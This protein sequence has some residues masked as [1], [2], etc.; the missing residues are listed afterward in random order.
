MY[1]FIEAEKAEYSVERL[2]EVLEV[3][4]SAFYRWRHTKCSQRRRDDRELKTH[5]QAIFREHKG[6]YGSPRVRHELSTR[7]MHVSRKRVARLM[8]EEGLAARSP[9]RFRRTT[10]SRHGGAIAPNLLERNFIVDERNKVWVGDVTYL[11]TRDR[12]LYLAVLIDLYSRRVVGWAM[13]DIID[14]Q[15]VRDALRMA[16]RQR[17]PKPGLIHHTDRD[18]RYASEDYREVLTELGATPSMSRKG[19]CWDNAVAE[20]FFATLEH[21][22]FADLPLQSPE[23]TRALV[24]DYIE[25]YYNEKRLHSYLDYRSPISYELGAPDKQ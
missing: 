18:C 4:R 6:R 9:K 2:C 21:E 5:V 8:C 20:S 14:T 15:L 19:N 7:G 13:S 17:K 22:L 12:W 16:T 25:R 23:R 11:P 3:S 10:D 1:E 24:A